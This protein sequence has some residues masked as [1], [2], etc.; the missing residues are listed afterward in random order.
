MSI[1]QMSK[2]ML[3]RPSPQKNDSLLVSNTSMLAASLCGRLILSNTHCRAVE[4]LH[5]TLGNSTTSDLWAKLFFSSK[6][7]QIFQ[8]A[9]KVLSDAWFPSGFKKLQTRGSCL[10]AALRVS[11]S[12]T[13]IC[14][15]VGGKRYNG[16]PPRLFLSAAVSL[17]FIPLS[18]R[19]SWGSR[20]HWLNLNQEN[21][22]CP[23]PPSLMR[24]AAGF[25]RCC[26]AL[27]SLARK[28]GKKE[29]RPRCSGKE[30]WKKWIS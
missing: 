10:N 2:V 22:L 9:S 21:Q 30:A 12:T 17:S 15:L 1:D 16:V 18:V 27:F 14:N 24:K 11:D 28:K 3:S 8:T 26:S 13:L 6:Q 23:H 20:F 5:F 7:M 29:K 4:S 19:R 25:P